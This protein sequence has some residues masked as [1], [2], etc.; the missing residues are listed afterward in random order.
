MASQRELLAEKNVVQNG[1]ILIANKEKM[2]LQSPQKK[3]E[4]PLLLSIITII[5]SIYFYSK[6]LVLGKNNKF[7]N[8]E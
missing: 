7:N 6:S 1:Q 5:I 4:N 2:F 8:N 3:K